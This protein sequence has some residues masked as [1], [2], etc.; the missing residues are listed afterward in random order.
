MFEA[1]SEQPADKILALVAA[2]KERASRTPSSWERNEGLS[3]KR[4]A[5]RDSSGTLDHAPP[6]TM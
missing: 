6:R 4:Q 5:L 1:L 3:A 2:Y